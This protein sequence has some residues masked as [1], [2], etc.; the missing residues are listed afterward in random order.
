MNWKFAIGVALASAALT[1]PAHAKKPV[2]A[3]EAEIRSMIERVYAPYSQPYPDPPEDGSALPDNDPGKL[4]QSKLNFGGQFMLHINIGQWQVVLF[5]TGRRSHRDFPGFWFNTGGLRFGR[6][7][8]SF[9]LVAIIIVRRVAILVLFNQVKVRAKVSGVGP[10]GR[11]PDHG[12]ETLLRVLDMRLVVTSDAISKALV[13]KGR[14]EFPSAFLGDTSH[15]NHKIIIKGLL[16][17]R[18]TLRG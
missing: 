12:S 3:D 17:G 1:A 18:L 13:C 8:F 6:L 11:I 16:L 14:M 2:A 7:F 9:I 10:F 5:L 4:R 15:K